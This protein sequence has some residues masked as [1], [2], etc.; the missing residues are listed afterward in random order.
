MQPGQKAGT[1]E[2]PPL[3]INKFCR[4]PAQRALWRENEL[5]RGSAVALPL[6]K[7]RLQPHVDRLGLH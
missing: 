7:I 6:S 3:A 2:K 1:K 5:S 4:L